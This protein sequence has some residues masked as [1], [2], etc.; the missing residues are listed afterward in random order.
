MKKRNDL[1]VRPDVFYNSQFA[2]ILKNDHSQREL[3]ELN[4]EDLFAL[5]SEIECVLSRFGY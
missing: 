4:E 3:V 1:K 5:K 2:V